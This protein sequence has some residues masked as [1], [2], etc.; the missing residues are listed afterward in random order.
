RA[1]GCG[2]LR[3][4]GEAAQQFNEV[5]H[6]RHVFRS[7]CEDGHAEVS[8]LFVR[9]AV[10][11]RQ[12]EVGFEFDDAL[13]VG[14]ETVTDERQVSAAGLR[15]QRIGRHEQVRTAELQQCFRVARHEA[16]DPLRGCREAYFPVQVIVDRYVPGCGQ[17]GQDEDD[18]EQ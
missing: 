9:S 8:E 5:K 7:A 14:A 2:F 10:R 13:E 17:A 12:Y 1:H 16:H 6:V 4:A 18:G 3:E 15:A 11:V